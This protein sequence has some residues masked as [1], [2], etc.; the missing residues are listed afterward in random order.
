MVPRSVAA[1]IEIALSALAGEGTRLVPSFPIA[2]TQTMDALTASL[3]RR[4]SEP[5]PLSP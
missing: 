1:P 2:T 5:L 4:A 3:T